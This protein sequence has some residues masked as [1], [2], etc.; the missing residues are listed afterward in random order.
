LSTIDLN[1]GFL[2]PGVYVQA[3]QTATPTAATLAADV[4]AIVGPA[5]GWM[6]FTDSMT[7][8]QTT[9]KPLSQE[10]INQTTIVVTDTSGNVQAASGYII[11]QTGTAPNTTTTIQLASGSPMTTTQTYNITYSFTDS[12]YYTPQIFQ[13]QQ[14]LFSAFGQPFGSTGGVAS[15]I[16]LAGMLALQGASVVVIMPT[17]DTTGVAT[18]IGLSNAYVQL[19]A[20]NGIDL[21]VPLP[22]G[23]TGS[24][25]APGDIANVAADLS[26]HC[27]MMSGPSIAYNRCGIV[28]YESTVTVAPDTTAANINDMRIMMVWPNAYGYYNSQSNVT[29]NVGGYYAA[30]KMAAILAGQP[31][32]RG[33]T[34]SSISGFAG[35]PNNVLSTMT[36]PY[37]NQLSAA[38]VAVIEPAPG[39]GALWCRYGTTTA[40]ANALTREFSLVR[41]SDAIMQEFQNTYNQAGIIGDPITSILITTINN[42]A[43]AALE[44][45]LSQS[46]IA[47]YNQPTSVQSTTNPDEVDVS[48]G[49]NPMYP[50]NIINVTYSVNQ[51][52]GTVAPATS[53]GTNSTTSAYS[54]STI[55]SS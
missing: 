46:I 26:A 31:K 35:I 13:D 23:M 32:N 8:L 45:L 24:V 50:L 42:L 49:Y 37:K 10:G 28:G 41:C 43:T 18:R 4:I 12:N 52:T 44:Y 19:E 36:V 30:A 20:I 47:G 27:D 14:T 6:T 16:S 54:G 2:A 33:L 9:A 11:V 48:F 40:P 53:T 15:P 39:T 1:T 5:Q 55:A 25:T 3:V 17:T 51:T 22:V 34:R 7:L 38:G 29:F 21:I